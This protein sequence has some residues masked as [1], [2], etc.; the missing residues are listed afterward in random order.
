[1]ALGKISIGREAKKRGDW[2]KSSKESAASLEKT[3]DQEYEPTEI[4]TS[5]VSYI[6]ASE[7]KGKHAS[8]HRAPS[9]HSKQKD[10]TTAAIL[11]VMLG[12]LGIHKFYLGSFKAGLIHI[13][14][15]PVAFILSAII[16][17][18]L[19]MTVVGVF[20]IVE[21]VLYTF[22]TDEQFNQTYVED[23]RQWL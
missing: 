21:G 7:R 9:K 20:P 13:A 8:D 3:S 4:S 17:I 23:G 5:S 15:V 10:P 18:W 19:P 16:G 1:M 2:L 12:W 6:P 14:A 22:K 11:A